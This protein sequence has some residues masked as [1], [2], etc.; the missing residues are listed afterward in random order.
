MSPSDEHLTVRQQRGGSG[1]ARLDH[2]SPRVP[3]PRARP[4]L[5]S[6]LLDAVRRH[7]HA[8]NGVR[9]S[10]LALHSVLAQSPQPTNARCARGEEPKA[11]SLTAGPALAGSNGHKRLRRERNVR[12]D[13]RPQLREYLAWYEE[14]LGRVESGAILAPGEQ[15]R[16]TEEASAVAHLLDL[17]DSSAEEPAS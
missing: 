13:I 7:S 5:S 1:H 16:L 10:E 11:R 14:V 15:E 6:L 3:R 12:P 2:G 17:L 4:S 8:P 9:C